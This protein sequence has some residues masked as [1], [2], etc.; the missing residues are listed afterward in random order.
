MDLLCIALFYTVYF[1]VVFLFTCPGTTDANYP[2]A[3]AG[4]ITFNCV[5]S[6]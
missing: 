3:N 2:Q 4:E 5:L 1:S 6:L